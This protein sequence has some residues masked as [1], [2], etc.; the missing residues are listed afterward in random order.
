M[1]G[2]NSAAASASAANSRRVTQAG[3]DMARINSA[4]LNKERPLT[5]V[6]G[7]PYMFNLIE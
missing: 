3:I 1:S 7:L 2:Q 6:L 4:M 5:A